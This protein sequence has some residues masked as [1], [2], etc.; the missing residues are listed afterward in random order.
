MLHAWHLTLSWSSP[1][2]AGSQLPLS[3]PR[4]DARQN[5][6][7]SLTCATASFSP[8]HVHLQASRAAWGLFVWHGAGAVSGWRLAPFACTRP[9]RSTW[10]LRS[11]RSVAWEFD[12]SIPRSPPAQP[13]ALP[14]HALPRPACSVRCRRWRCA[15]GASSCAATGPRKPTRAPTRPSPPPPTQRWPPWG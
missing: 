6:I 5:L 4:S 2:P 12:F 10:H 3:Q 11:C 9:T 15:L 13:P 14:A 7:D 1:A 8:P